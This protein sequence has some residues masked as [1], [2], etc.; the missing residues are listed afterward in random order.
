MSIFGGT[1]II[2]TVSYSHPASTSSEPIRGELAPIPPPTEFNLIHR[3]NPYAS[4]PTAVSSSYAVRL[5]NPAEELR[6]EN[7][8]SNDSLNIF[9]LIPG[10]G[11]TRHG[12]ITRERQNEI[13]QRYR[14]RP[15]P[16]FDP[17]NNR[18]SYSP[19]VL[20]YTI[21]PSAFYL[22]HGV[23]QY[24]ET[25]RCIFP[26]DSGAQSLSTYLENVQRHARG[27]TGRAISVEGDQFNISLSSNSAIPYQIQEFP[28]TV[29]NLHTSSSPAQVV[30]SVNVTPPSSPQI[31]CYRIRAVISE[32]GFRCVSPAS[33]TITVRWR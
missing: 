8:N 15:V 32:D 2:P 16:N 30:A 13:C 4:L 20:D 14:Y 29:A 23:M 22:E 1:K 3:S 19:N 18:I 12:P 27:E 7:P 11:C 26:K 28:L 33:H 31:D 5:L 21:D 25:G 17:E 6:A 24:S 9:D 10:V